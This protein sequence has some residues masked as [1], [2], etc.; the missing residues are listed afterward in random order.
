M[1]PGEAAP[2]TVHDA[3]QAALVAISALCGRAD[4]VH[5]APGPKPSSRT[6]SRRDM[7]SFSMATLQQP[8]DA[9]LG[10][11]M[12]FAYA[13]CALPYRDGGIVEF[14]RYDCGPGPSNDL[15]LH[16][17][18]DGR[19]EHY[20]ILPSLYSLRGGDAVDAATSLAL[21]GA[22]FPAWISAEAGTV[23]LPHPDKDDNH[24]RIG[25]TLVVYEGEQLFFA[26][27]EATARE[28][29]EILAELTG[30]EP[31]FTRMLERPELTV[32]VMSRGDAVCMR[33]GVM[34][35]VVTSV[36]KLV[37]SCHHR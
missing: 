19:L 9:E 35:M 3:A 15:T 25:T 28:E 4:K 24:K 10:R 34:H 17:N 6:R 11:V 37:L 13:L 7:S 18:P 31:V 1:A 21:P 14:K 5:R 30:P 12:R 27:E 22:L 26:W 16:G 2:R 20:D 36:S 23:T 33:A 8:L 29:A 32:R